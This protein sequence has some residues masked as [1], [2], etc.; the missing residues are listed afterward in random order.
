MKNPGSLPRRKS[1]PERHYV[2]NAEFYKALTEYLEKRKLAI[3]ENREIPRIPEYI[4]V[5]IDKIARRLSTKGNF[6]GYTFRE[7]MVSDGIETCFKYLHSFDP[8]RTDRAFSYFTR[9]IYNSFLHRISQEKREVYIKYKAYENGMLSGI[10]TR[11]GSTSDDTASLDL[12]DNMIA[13][14]NDYESKLALKKK[15]K[16]KGVELFFEESDLSE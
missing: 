13:F 14:V 3:Q 7:E 1:S 8:S 6:S 12:T 10:A 9:I 11:D 16:T 5:C 4:G 2:N 15:Q